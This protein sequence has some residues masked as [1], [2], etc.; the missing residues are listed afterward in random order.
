MKLPDR[1]A[2]LIR[3]RVILVALLLIPTLM[4]AADTIRHTIRFPNPET[5]YAEV[6]VVVPTGSQASIELMMAVWTPGSY[7]VRDYSGK[8]ESER[9]ETLDGDDFRKC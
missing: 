9:A 2:R 7:L 8:V 1:A 6:E 4:Q 3:R 5:H